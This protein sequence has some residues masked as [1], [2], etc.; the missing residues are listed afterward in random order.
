MNARSAASRLSRS[1]GRN[2]AHVARFWRD[3]SDGDLDL[4]QRVRRADRP[5]AAARQPGAAA[6]QARE[7]VLPA[8]AIRTEHRDAQRLHLVV[9]R[10][11]ERLHV[12]DDAELREAR[13]VVGMDDLDVRDVMPMIGRAIGR[14]GSLDGVERQ[15]DRPVADGVEVRLEAAPVE[16]DDGLAKQ[17]G[18]DER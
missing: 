1:S 5:V 15:A 9:V 14:P 11:P 17:I 16:L 7:R 10:R 6:Q 4:E 13:D 2:G 12:G 3:A 18:I 8:G